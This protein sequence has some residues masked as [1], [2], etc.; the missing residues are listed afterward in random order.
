MRDLP[1]ENRLLLP[2]VC[3]DMP[4]RKQHTARFCFI[5]YK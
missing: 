3:A 4:Q 5:G 2:N 1:V